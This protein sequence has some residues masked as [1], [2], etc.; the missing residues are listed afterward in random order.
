MVYQNDHAVYIRCSCGC[1]DGMN[2]H[3]TRYDHEPEYWISLTG[4]LHYL[5]QN[6]GWQRLK[7][8]LK[9]LWAVLANRDYQYFELMLTQQE[10][11]EFV[12]VLR[13]IQPEE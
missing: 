6:H 2:F 10:F 8:K 5:E 3:V 11:S 9:K 1:G 7:K 12:T 13:R 4:D